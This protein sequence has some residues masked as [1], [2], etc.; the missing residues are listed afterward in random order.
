MRTPITTNNNSIY[1]HLR[2]QWALAATIFA[3]VWIL[4]IFGMASLW[5]VQSVL[6]W[7]GISAIV[8]AYQMFDL[9][10]HLRDNRR[11][12][13]S[14]LLDSFGPGTWLTIVRGL[15][16]GL[17]AGFLFSPHMLGWQAW[18]P[19]I[20]YTASA[21][22]DYLD[23]YLARISEHDT[24]LGAHLDLEFD[25]F[26]LFIAVWLAIWY[27]RIPLWFAPVGLARYAFAFGEQ[28]LARSGKRIHQLPSS[29]SRRPAA[30]FM[31]GFFTV[32]QWPIVPPEAAL[33]AGV[34]FLFP[35]TT[36]FVRDWVVVAG[37][38]NPQGE[39]YLWLRNGLKTILLG[40]LPI[41]VR[42][43]MLLALVSTIS[44]LLTI[45]QRSSIFFTHGF[46]AAI[47]I[48]PIFSVV[49]LITIVLII[50]GTLPRF[51]AFTLLFPIGL[52]IVGLGMG[53][54]L[55]FTLAGALLILILGSGR[56]SL[57]PLEEKIFAR[58][59]GEPV[60]SV[61]SQSVA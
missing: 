46:P 56:G 24:L 48:A 61:E 20:L 7:S 59:A 13:E 10:R 18:I 51:A 40:W 4:G 3:L 23:G 45:N 35:F 33:L 8:L 6:S 52:T 19:A 31:M 42:F 17:L 49:E 32:M 16:L 29:S 58:R 57:W 39:K 5:P 43:G 15:F 12:A 50:S 11:I 21:I 41:L 53:D 38:L 26:G 22:A 37:W 36:G 54:G 28:L 27:G 60:Q 14:P 30:G 55:G 1:Q 44:H 9:H 25:A 2:R 47:W 34:I